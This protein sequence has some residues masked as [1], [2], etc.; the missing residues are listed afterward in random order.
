[1]DQSCKI[2]NDIDYMDYQTVRIE[3]QCMNKYVLICHC[4]H[5][6][7]WHRLSII[8]EQKHESTITFCDEMNDG[9][10]G[11]VEREFKGLIG[12]H[13]NYIDHVPIKTEFIVRNSGG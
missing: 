12:H 2:S 5:F 6:D 7:N 10:L 9:D 4:I 1:M 13:F 11:T 8:M 3:G